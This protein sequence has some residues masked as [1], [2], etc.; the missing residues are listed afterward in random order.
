MY[1]VIF[2]VVVANFI[3]VAVVSHTQFIWNEMVKQLSIGGW[4]IAAAAPLHIED[5]FTAFCFI[6]HNKKLKIA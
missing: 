2:V 3:F 4:S 5:H 6:N 1:F